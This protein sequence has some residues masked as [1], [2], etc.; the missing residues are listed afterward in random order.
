MAADSTPEGTLAAGIF[1]LHSNGPLIESPFVSMR[2][3]DPWGNPLW[4]AHLFDAEEA[5]GHA[6]EFID[7]HPFRVFSQFPQLQ[8]FTVTT[9]ASTKPVPDLVYF[10][11]PEGGMCEEK[12]LF[13]ESTLNHHNIW[14]FAPLDLIFD[15]SRSCCAF[16]QVG[17][18]ARAL[19]PHSFWVLLLYKRASRGI[20][21]WLLHCQKRS[22]WRLIG[23]GHDIRRIHQQ[24][25]NGAPSCGGEEPN[26]KMHSLLKLLL[27]DQ[28]DEV[29]SFRYG[30]YYPLL[31]LPG[32][33]RSGGLHFWCMH[34]TT[35]I[36]PRSY[37]RLPPWDFLVALRWQ[38]ELC[39]FSKKSMS[40][41]A[42]V[43]GVVP[44]DLVG[45]GGGQ[46]RLK[47]FE[48]SA[49]ND[50]FLLFVF[51][52]CRRYNSVIPPLGVRN[53]MLSGAEK[54]IYSLDDAGAR[55]ILNFLRQKI[56]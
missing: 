2:E 26:E 7:N 51:T 35:F 10:L 56:S 12:L 28:F 9:Q 34:F 38:W 48:K 49:I 41:P 33:G 46:R 39:L 25:N 53:W 43:T 29:C 21:T 50:W 16:L 3:S 44:F 15:D 11:S 8:Y 14:S 30:A 54:D 17:Q 20:R 55:G 19:K 31:G 52:T 36:P 45:G 47:I 23:R 32:L 5:W 40:S 37:Y 24:S 22:D 18:R 42:D 13:P 6:E 27:V 1:F 4:A